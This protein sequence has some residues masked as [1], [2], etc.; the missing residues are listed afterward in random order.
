MSI[1]ATKDVA[2]IGVQRI[3]TVGEVFDPRLH[4]AV[5]MEDG[6][7]AVEVVCEELQSGYLLGDEVIRHAMVRVRMEQQS[8][9]SGTKNQAKEQQNGSI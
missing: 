4:E 7:G 8:Q 1:P 3:K 9:E 6:D 5:S 2:D